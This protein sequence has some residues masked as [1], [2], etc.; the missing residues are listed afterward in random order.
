VRFDFQNQKP[1]DFLTTKKMRNS[2]L[3]FIQSKQR[4]YHMV[5]ASAILQAVESSIV[6]ARQSKQKQ[7]RFSSLRMSEAGF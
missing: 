2:S 4:Q 7:P 1:F 6:G 3:D 5:K